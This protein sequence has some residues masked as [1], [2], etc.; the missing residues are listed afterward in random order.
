MTAHSQPPPE[1][2][3]AE[4]AGPLLI[5]RPMM[6]LAAWTAIWFAILA[7]NGGIAWVFFVKGSSLLFDGTF[8]HHNRPGFMHVYA[9]Y[10]GLQIGPLS[11]VVAQAIRTLGPDQGLVLAQVVM[12]VI[13]LG[14]LA[15]LRRIALLARPELARQRAF[16]WTFLAGGALFMVAWTEL[17]V[18][19][20]HLDDALALL[21]AAAALWAAITG[22]PV[23]T[24][25]G[26][27]LAADAKPWA[28]IFLPVLLLS[29]GM[30]RWRAA[31]QAGSPSR[32]NLP[33]WL[34]AGA[35]TAIVIAAAW[36]PFFIA[37]PETARALH[38]T[39]GNMPDSALRALGVTTAR[40]PPWD[41][42][43]QIVIACL[44]GLAA[45]RRRRWPTVLLLGAGARIALDPGSHGYYTPSIMVGALLWDLLGARRPLPVWTAISF[46]A[47]NLVPLLIA[48]GPVRGAFRLYLVVAFT[49]AILLGRRRWAWQPTTDPV[50]KVSRPAAAETVTG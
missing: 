39:I 14:T 44:L 11:F 9:S 31:D 49:L 34:L 30:S 6:P 17:A 26:I 35:C 3:A 16:Y 46:C 43:A 28:L 27:G 12:S 18:A 37:A 22:H 21:L 33:A 25:L 10:P 40:T 38:Y 1:A 8:N 36:L 24:G 45:I 29:G 19:Y 20:G 5:R 50:P 7:R 13:G 4:P 15:I 41:R 2:S 42:Q 23:L 48:S 32:T 47:L